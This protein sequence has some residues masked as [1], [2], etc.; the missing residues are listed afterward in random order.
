MSTERWIH[1]AIQF[2][3]NPFIKPDFFTSHYF[4]ILGFVFAAQKAKKFR[5]LRS[6]PPTPPSILCTNSLPD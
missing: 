5:R 2:L 6:L 4:P 1:K 3:D